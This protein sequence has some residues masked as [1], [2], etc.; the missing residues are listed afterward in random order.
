MIAGRVGGQGHPVDAETGATAKK[1]PDA[2]MAQAASSNTAGSDSAEHH[3]RRPEDPG[4]VGEHRHA[5]GS[6]R[7]LI[8]PGSGGE[9]D[10]GGLGHRHRR[11]GPVD[12]VLEEQGVEF[13]GY[14]RQMADASDEPRRGV[15]S[16]FICRNSSKLISRR[17][18]VARDGGRSLSR[19]NRPYPVW[20]KVRE[21]QTGRPSAEVDQV[22]RLGGSAGLSELLHPACDGFVTFWCRCGVSLPGMRKPR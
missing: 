9:V 15:R 21:F 3:H 4:W 5:A 2:L 22:L 12:L 16:Q 14:Q 6:L 7:S 17:R 20:H 1:K 13:L 19:G 10:G 11:K 18:R 8:R